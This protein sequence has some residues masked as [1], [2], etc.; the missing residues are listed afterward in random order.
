MKMVVQEELA[1]KVKLV[2]GMK[3]VVC[4]TEEEGVEEQEAAEMLEATELEV[5]GAVLPL[6][7]VVVRAVLLAV[8]VKVR[9][10]LL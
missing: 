8:M 7:I 2:V 10:E 3:G 5:A 9:Q 1:V 4:S 6:Q